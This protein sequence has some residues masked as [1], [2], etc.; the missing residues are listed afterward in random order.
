MSV[1]VGEVLDFVMVFF[2][3]KKDSVLIIGGVINEKGEFFFD[4]LFGL[5]FVK[6]EFILFKVM[7]ID[8]IDL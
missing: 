6:V 2:F 5:Y 3:V 4:V 7:V 1:D 8:N